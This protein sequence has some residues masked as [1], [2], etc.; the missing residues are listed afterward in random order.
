MV[1]GIVKAAIDITSTGPDLQFSLVSPSCWYVELDN[2]SASRFLG[3]GSLYKRE[4]FEDS[5]HQIMV[6][7]KVAKKVEI[8]TLIQLSRNISVR[9]HAIIF[10]QTFM[11]LNK[12]VHKIWAPSSQFFLLIHT[13]L[14]SHKLTNECKQLT[15][16]RK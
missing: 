1:A 11:L 9:M 15:S 2:L 5:A 12:K 14:L 10:C 13:V 7:E 4:P 8:F 6:K 3:S 16:T